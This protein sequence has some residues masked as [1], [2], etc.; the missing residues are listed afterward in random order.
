MTARPPDK[1][2]RSGHLSIIPAAA[3]FDPNLG[4]AALRVLCALGAF[5]NRQGNCWPATTTLA[6]ELGISD[7]RVRV[8]LRELEANDYLR[9]EHRPGQRSTYSILRKPLDPGT[10]ASGVEPNPGTP[11]SGGAEHQHPGTPEHQ[12][13]PNGV[14]NV[15]KND[16]AFSGAIVRLT[17]Q[18]FSA[19]QEAYKAIPDLRAA[20]QQRDDWLAKLPSSDRRQKDWFVPISNWLANQNKRARVE[21]DYDPDV[22]H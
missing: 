2:P 1:P 21:P 9:T 14:T 8:C 22:I 15:T 3:A 4:K 19:W 16:Y 7:R 5:A 20:L 6:A 11:A 10:P 18:N 13:P 12:H 17:W